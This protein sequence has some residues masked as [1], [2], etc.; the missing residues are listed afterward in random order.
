VCGRKKARRHKHE[1]TV[2]CDGSAQS[3]AKNAQ[4]QSPEDLHDEMQ[5][6][7]SRYRPELQGLKIVE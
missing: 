2:G 7:G 1:G 3:A 5:S 4:A 6:D